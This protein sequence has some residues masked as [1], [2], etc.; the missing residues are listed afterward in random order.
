MRR[1]RLGRN[2][3]KSASEC[4]QLGGLRITNRARDRRPRRGWRDLCHRQLAEKRTA[5][6]H[7][8]DRDYPPAQW[9]VRRFT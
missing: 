1:A 4:I 2:N 5:S 8:G 9:A 6:G 7:R 3:S